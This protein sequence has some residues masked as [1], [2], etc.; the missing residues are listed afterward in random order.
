MGHGIDILMR[1][2]QSILLNSLSRYGKTQFRLCTRP[3]RCKKLKMESFMVLGSNDAG[4]CLV[5]LI[6]TFLYFLTGKG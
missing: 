3:I 5:S 2:D 1:P 4:G 6:N